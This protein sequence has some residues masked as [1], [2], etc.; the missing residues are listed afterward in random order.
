MDLEH[1][2]AK[3]EREN[4]RL[5]LAGLLGLMLI[6]AVFVMG[7]ART[8]QRIEA[9]NFVVKDRRGV[10]L[11]VLGASY[12][13]SPVSSDVGTPMLSYYSYEPDGRYVIRTYF[14]GEAAGDGAALRLGSPNGAVALNTGGDTSG[15]SIRISDPSGV[16]WSV[17]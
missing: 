10:V 15:P 14:Q 11:A 9:E 12:P 17:P 4:R 13:M 8:P 6:G 16:V 3:L 2:V 7:Q 5:R 1:R